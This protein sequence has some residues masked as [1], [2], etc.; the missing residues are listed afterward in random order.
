MYCFTSNKNPAGRWVLLK[1]V[2]CLLTRSPQ[3]K[4]KIVYPT[5]R[6]TLLGSRLTALVNG[7]WDCVRKGSPAF[8][9]MF[10]L[11]LPQRLCL[12]VE[13]FSPF[14]SWIYKLPTP[15]DT[16]LLH[17]VDRQTAGQMDG[18]WVQ[19]QIDLPWCALVHALGV[20]F[21]NIEARR[22]ETLWSVWSWNAF[23]KPS[24]VGTLL[25]SFLHSLIQAK[26]YLTYTWNWDELEIWI[27][28]K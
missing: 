23:A 15:L 2:V 19:W 7:T 5:G 25:H 14:P 4:K 26:K 20:R 17:L 27:W 11:S 16:G 13:V 22:G 3:L 24:V 10:S 9:W 12:S 21:A 18:S 28:T 6:V 8:F 1:L